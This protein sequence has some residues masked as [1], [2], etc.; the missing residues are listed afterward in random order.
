AKADALAV[1]GACGAP[2]ENLRV[3]RDA[4]G[5]YHPG[6]SG[7]LGLGPNVLAL[8]GEIHPGV[9]DAMGLAGPVAGFEVFLHR[10]PQPRARSGKTR[11]PLNASPF[12]PLGRDFAFVVDADVP[13]DSLV[14]AARGADKALIGQVGV[15]DVYQGKG[16]GE[17]KKSIAIAVTLQPRERTLTDQDIEKVS[18]AIVAAVAKQTGGVLRG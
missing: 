3:T 4:P 16:V 5:W 8:F 10:I 18:A 13:A 11:P 2:V 1:L 6:R 17:G 7:A 12:Q 14:R 15:F 9:L